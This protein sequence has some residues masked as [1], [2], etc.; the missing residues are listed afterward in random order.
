MNIS[1]ESTSIILIVFDC[2]PNSSP[3]ETNLIPKITVS[4]PS[5]ISS[6]IDL[7]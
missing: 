7:T 2:D 4:V 6:S 3:L 1:P 5:G